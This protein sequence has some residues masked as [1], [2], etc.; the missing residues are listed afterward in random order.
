MRDANTGK[1]TLIETAKAGK[2]NFD[3]IATMVQKL[4]DQGL[5]ADAGQIARKARANLEDS[6]ENIVY[7]RT[8]TEN[9]AE[10]LLELGE[11]MGTGDQDLA[12]E[13]LAD[14]TKTASNISQK[15]LMVK[16]D[17][18]AA[19]EELLNKV[20]DSIAK[21]ANAQK[22]QTV[23]TVSSIATGTGS[24]ITAAATPVVATT[25]ASLNLGAVGVTMVAVCP[26]TLAAG[27]V[28]SAVLGTMAYMNKTAAKGY[29]VQAASH[30][31]MAD[32]TNSIVQAA[33]MNQNL[34]RGIG[35]A[36]KE[37]Q[38]NVDALGKL[39]PRR[40]QEFKRRTEALAKSL[41]IFVETLDEYLV[42]LSLCKYFPGNYPLE[43]KLGKQRYHEMRRVLMNN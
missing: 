24:V 34:W 14:V 3:L 4:Q 38:D 20:Q 25:V 9:I 12:K 1:N 21:Q 36:A 29:G 13:T 39:N 18:S 17:Y 37:L 6:A 33:D 5:D 22:W 16:A 2:F 11:H 19:E 28:G 43:L 31:E 8:Q 27:L 7:L 30:K 15:S 42:W 32:M 10:F 23:H 26:Y 41:R 35:M 40:K